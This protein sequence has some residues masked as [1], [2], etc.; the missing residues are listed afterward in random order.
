MLQRLT[1]LLR[2]LHDAGLQP[3]ISML[4]ADDGMA[5]VCAVTHGDEIREAAQAYTAAEAA[6]ATDDQIAASIE[7]LAAAA[8][9]EVS[10]ARGE[11]MTPEKVMDRLRQAAAQS[12]KNQAAD[13][14][15]MIVP[16]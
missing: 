7:T 3:Q 8:W 13:R 4:A 1:L 9:C 2:Q 6:A 10:E 11:D 16:H 12:P 5:I 14:L 15:A